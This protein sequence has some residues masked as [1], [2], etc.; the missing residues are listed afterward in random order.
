MTSPSPDDNTPLPDRHAAAAWRA[1]S[2][3][4]PPA[5]LDAAILAAARREIGAGPRPVS[6][7]RTSRTRRAWWPLAAAAT[8]GAIAFGLLQLVTPDQLGAPVADNAV[9]TD[10]PPP[11]AK[12]A[13]EV[14]STASRE[15]APK[16]SALPAAKDE[17][18][19]RRA[20][21]PRQPA[22]ATVAT[23]QSEPA[24]VSRDV[25]AAPEPF[26]AAPS[27]RESTA[28]ANAA[29]APAAT[30]RLAEPAPSTMAPP[31]PSMAAQGA[32][33]LPSAPKA[34]LGKVA[35]ER[36]S[37]DTAVATQARARDR[38]PLPVADWIALIRRLRDEGKSD[39]AGKELAAFRA[40]HA[41]HQR[42]LPP[43]LRDW[44]PPEK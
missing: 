10:V 18:A 11:A 16:V 5:A 15:T 42:L 3:E 35:A 44:R 1:A 20:E 30:V 22:A 36:A 28:D 40:A 27:Q 29:S 23:G 32:S 43:D 38:A 6:A 37:D 26:P 25:A 34:P 17:P 41:D 8:I 24:R 19:A 2:A 39:E 31:A 14:A 13:Q 21:A 12:R 7:G 9:V 33:A 4:E